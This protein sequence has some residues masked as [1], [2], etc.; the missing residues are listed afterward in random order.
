MASVSGSCHLS[1]HPDHHDDSD[2]TSD[3]ER[4]PLVP[5][6]REQDEDGAPASQDRRA[7]S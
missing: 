2:L 6:D 5:D 3:G 1:Q 7:P 4:H